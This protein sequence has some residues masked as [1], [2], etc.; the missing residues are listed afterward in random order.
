MESGTLVKLANLCLLAFVCLPSALVKDNDISWTAQAARDEIRPAFTNAEDGTLVIATDAREGLAGHWEKSFPIQGGQP[1]RFEA[2]WRAE[3]LSV[4]RTA[5]FSR[6]HWRD[7]KGNQVRHEKIGATAFA[8]NELPISEPE[9]P[10]DGAVEADGWHHIDETYNVPP[11]ATQAIVELHLRWAPNARVEWRD[12]ALVPASPLPPRKVRLAAIHFS[13]NGT[14]TA[15]ENRELFAPLVAKAAEQHAD[16]A[17]LPEA[18]TCQG[19]GL[20]Y[21]DVAEPVPGPSTKYFGALAKQHGLYLVA[22]IVEKDGYLMYNTAILMDPEGKLAGKYRKVTL[23]RLEEEWGAMPGHEYP[24]FDTKF[25]RLGIMICYDGFFP[26]VARE[27]SNRG[28]E[29]IAFPVAGC[30]PLLAAAR[31]VENHTFIVSSTYC[32]PEINWMLSGVFDREGKI[33][34]KAKDWGDVVV[35]EV[36]LNDRLYWSSLGD[37]RDEIPRHR[38]VWSE[39]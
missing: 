31:A 28:A 14:K 11:D 22:G 18:L 7:A 25:G 15:Q 10:P 8:P 20:M 5:V 30:N 9:Y 37:F 24:V 19:N 39:E 6:I 26:E 2:R 16:L 29:V 34:A 23:P 4:T 1:Y 12:M 27:L 17:V 36:D 13:P 38:P 32:P 21:A 35:A 3:G 33:I